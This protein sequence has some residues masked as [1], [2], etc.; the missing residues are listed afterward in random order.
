M[1]KSAKEISY[2]VYTLQ[3]KRWELH[4][5]YSVQKKSQALQDAKA[6]DGISTINGVKVVEETAMSGSSNSQEATIFISES[7]KEEPKRKRPPKASPPPKPVPSESKAPAK[8]ATSSK[9]QRNTKKKKENDG[10]NGP[11]KPITFS[12]FLIRFM[13]IIL[14]G[15]FSGIAAAWITSL[16]LQATDLDAGIQNYI[17]FGIF[18]LAFFIF[19][20][21]AMPLISASKS[22]PVLLGALSARNLL[23][24]RDNEEP[25]EPDKAIDTG[26]YQDFRTEAARLKKHDADTFSDEEG[27]ETDE[28][29]DLDDEPYMDDE[30]IDDEVEDDDKDEDED[31][32][33]YVELSNKPSPVNTHKNFVLRYLS[34]ALKHAKVDKNQLDNFNKFG[35]TLYMAGA[36]DALS[37]EHSLDTK[38]S[39][40][41]ITMTVRFIGLSDGNS[42]NFSAKIQEYL[43]AD[44]KYM[45]AFQ[46]GHQAMKLHMDNN[47]AGIKNLA[48]ALEDWNKPKLKEE[49]KSPITVLFTDIAGSTE[50]TQTLGDA[51]AQQIVRIHNQIVRDALS[52]FSGKEIKHTGDGIMA[53]FANTSNAVS[54]SAD[55]QN[56]T[57]RHN[58]AKPDQ[59]WGLK[60]GLNTGEPIAEDND[61]FGSTVQLAARITDKAQ[62]NQVYVSEIVYGI[63]N[64]KNFRFENRGAF[65]MKGF[66]NGLVL[67]ELIWDPDA[68]KSDPHS[69]SEEPEQTPSAAPAEKIDNAMAILQANIV[70]YKRLLEMKQ[71]NTSARVSGIVDFAVETIKNKGGVILQQDQDMILATFEKAEVAVRISEVIQNKLHGLNNNMASGNKVLFR[72]GIDMGQTSD[73]EDAKQSTKDSERDKLASLNSKA[74]PGGLCV[75]SD[76]ISH[77]GDGMDIAFTEGDD[78]PEH[79]H[80]WNPEK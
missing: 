3:D 74:K 45:E 66:A 9:A 58:K 50:M 16:W 8:K 30:L 11:A 62:T 64:G 49:T 26:A 79:L 68:P 25:D 55:M 75:T 76:V 19:I 24:S 48:Q 41:I 53:S 56:A 51:S 78:Q 35:V 73:S 12:Q 5:V 21:A 60:I 80:R 65:E 34:A 63:C 27:P 22:K 17:L 54:A 57:A 10:D 61:L 37:R 32:D 39:S 7:Q 47:A 59:T 29:E 71:D 2:M 72:I 40:K 52:K 28:D 4:A 20:R 23:Q 15:I 67:H 33:Y 18:F 42:D 69:A 38:L 44:A 36:C 13:G 14:I 31:E 43:V 1:G 6:L 70:D 77:C 46:N